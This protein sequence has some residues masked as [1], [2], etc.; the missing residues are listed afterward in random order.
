MTAHCERINY[1]VENNITRPKR[2]EI[3]GGIFI[4][5]R[6]KILGSIKTWYNR[7]KQ[8]RE[9]SHMSDRQLKDIGLTRHD[10]ANM[11]RSYFWTV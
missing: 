3:L 9:L 7:Q 11:N 4:L 10:V 2:K 6:V 1:L 8:Q 5:V